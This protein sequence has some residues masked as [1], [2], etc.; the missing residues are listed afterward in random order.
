MGELFLFSDRNGHVICN[1]PLLP[2]LGL[3]NG[4]RDLSAQEVMTSPSTYMIVPDVFFKFLSWQTNTQPY[5]ILKLL[6]GG[7]WR[8]MALRWQYLKPFNCV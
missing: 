5:F 4:W 8:S 1:T 7:G 2:T 3:I 6:E